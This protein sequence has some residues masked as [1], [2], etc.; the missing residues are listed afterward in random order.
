MYFTNCVMS[1]LVLS[2]TIF[3]STKVGRIMSSPSPLSIFHSSQQLFNW[4]PCPR[5][6][7]RHPCCLGS[8]STPGAWSCALHDF[9]FK[10]ASFFLIT[11]QKYTSFL[12]LTDASK[13]LSTPAVLSTHSFVFF[14]VHET[15]R[16]CLKHF[17]SKALI[18]ASSGFLI[19]QLSHPYI[20]TGQ[21]SALRSRIFVDVEMPW[22]CQI[23]LSLEPMLWPFASRVWISLVHSLSSD[24]SWK[25][26]D[27]TH[28]DRYYCY[29]GLAYGS[30][31]VCAWCAI[32]RP[33][34]GACQQAII[35]SLVRQRYQHLGNACCYLLPP[36]QPF[37]ASATPQ[38]PRAVAVSVADNRWVNAARPL[39]SHHL[40]GLRRH[41]ES[42]HR[43]NQ[44]VINIYEWKLPTFG[45]TILCIL[46]HEMCAKSWAD[47]SDK[48]NNLGKRSLSWNFSSD[49]MPA[50][51]PVS[52][53]HVL[54]STMER[55]K[56]QLVINIIIA[57]FHL[58]FFS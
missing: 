29:G 41:S 6:N 31:S 55:D 40:Y 53:K 39:F 16:T 49:C 27:Y 1:C 17:I 23:F 38:S 2:S 43:R 46:V 4:Q 13:L 32:E 8:T 58:G 18:F 3:V 34:H 45:R 22:L 10:A 26:N 57:K 20:A 36:G 5:C 9:F 51:A 12:S 56:T 47:N 50:V 19:V 42:Q 24:V 11:C 15:L 44:C 28:I 25:S 52:P 48:C 33:L 30:F 14:A 37:A 7:V 54:N 21:T 35:R